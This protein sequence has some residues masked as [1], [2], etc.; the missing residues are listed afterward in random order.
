MRCFIYRNLNRRGYVYSLK[1]LEGSYKGRVVAYASKIFMTDVEFVV[2]QKGHARALRDM[3]RNVHAGIVGKVNTI[4]NCIHRLPHKI[5]EC[6]FEMVHTGVPITYNPWKYDS[7]VT[8]SDLKPIFKAR[9]AQI[10][11]RDVE[12]LL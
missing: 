2:G 4:Y 7:F 6:D 3:H 1:A 9:H 11:G 5:D 8:R 10:D 12:A